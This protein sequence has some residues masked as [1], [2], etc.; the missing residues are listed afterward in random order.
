M[1]VDPS[2]Y[3]VQS[4]RP[5]PVS[6]EWYKRAWLK[7]FTQDEVVEKIKN[8]PDLEFIKE[9]NRIFIPKLNINESNGLQ[10]TL[11]LDGVD[12]KPIQGQ[13]KGNIKALDDP[14]NKEVD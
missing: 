2:N 13:V 10:V 12:I 4:K 14:N 8:L 3:R 11:I 5:R 7:A 9:F 1:S 6:V